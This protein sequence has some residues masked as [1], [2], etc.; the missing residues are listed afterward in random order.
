LDVYR[1]AYIADADPA[2]LLFLIIQNLNPEAL[3]AFHGSEVARDT[4]GM[5]IFVD[6]WGNPIR[7][8][9]WVPGLTDSDL[10]RRDIPDPTDER[11]G[12]TGWL[13]YPL[14]Y[15]AGPDGIPGIIEGRAIIGTEGINTGILDPFGVPNGAP[16]GSNR[17][18]D[19]IHNH[20]RYRSFFFFFSEL[21][22]VGWKDYRITTKNSA[23]L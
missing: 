13:L 9:R 6:A 5:L 12:A 14:I 11:A 19:N 16:D 20:Q 15:S 17:H 4:N 2:A 18:F 21:G 3:E 10:M 7:F 23:I 8:L 22:F 1:N